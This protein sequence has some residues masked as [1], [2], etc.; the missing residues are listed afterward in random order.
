MRIGI[1][2]LVE[3]GKI[4]LDSAR[5]PLLL[6]PVELVGRLAKI[7]AGIGLQAGVDSQV[8]CA[9]TQI[10]RCT[11]HWRSWCGSAGSACCTNSAQSQQIRM[12]LLNRNLLLGKLQDIENSVPS[13]LN[14]FGLKLGQV[15]KQLLRGT[16]R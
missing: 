8:P 13:S 16:R 10:Q 12:L 5:L 15:A 14:V 1:S 11:Q 3:S 6:G 2:C 4:L 9:T 7:A